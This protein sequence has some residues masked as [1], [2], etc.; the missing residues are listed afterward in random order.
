VTVF[1][2]EEEA[3]DIDFSLSRSMD[4]WFLGSLY[5]VKGSRGARLISMA[6]R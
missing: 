5:G 2:A 1:I 4:Q 3:D 6:E